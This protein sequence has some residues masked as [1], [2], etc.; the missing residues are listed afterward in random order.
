MK[1]KSDPP[2]NLDQPADAHWI[3]KEELGR[4][5]WVGRRRNFESVRAA[6]LFIKTVLSEEERKTAWIAAEPHLDF[7]QITEI[8]R[9]IIA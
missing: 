1:M 5:G 9:Q 3:P 4:T 2:I 6:V 7:Q 8:Y